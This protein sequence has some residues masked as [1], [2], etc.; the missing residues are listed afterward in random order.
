LDFYEEGTFVTLNA[1]AADG[2]MFRGWVDDASGTTISQEASFTHQLTTSVS[3]TAR[4][5]PFRTVTTRWG[6]WPIGQWRLGVENTRPGFLPGG[7]TVTLNATAADGYVFR[8]WVDGVTT[9]STEAIF[10]YTITENKTFTARFSLVKAYTVTVT[11]NPAEGGRCRR[12][13]TKIHIGQAI[14]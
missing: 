6:W 10:Q 4:F 13:P 3:L 14:K 12:L 11:A 2:Y 8:G 1:V 7:T 5:K 9:V